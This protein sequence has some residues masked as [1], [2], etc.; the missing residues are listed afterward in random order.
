MTGLARDGDLDRERA[1]VDSRCIV[2]VG[3]CA[4]GKS[5][6]VDALRNLGYNA[7]VSAQEH[8]EIASLWRHL[9][10]DILIALEADIAAVHAR[11]GRDWPEWLHDVQVE[12]LSQAT[13]AADLLID[14]SGLAAP[15]VIEAVVR[16]LEGHPINRPSF[17]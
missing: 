14:T 8:S 16:F 11:R 2:V 6:V 7:Y 13:A 5:T 1:N 12:R 3:P 10:P 9:E 17:R 15:A 4:S